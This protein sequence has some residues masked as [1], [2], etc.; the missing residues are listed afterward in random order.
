MSDHKILLWYM[1]MIS[2]GMFF[3]TYWGNWIVTLTHLILTLIILLIF[4]FLEDI[5]NLNKNRR[6]K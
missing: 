4:I 6:Y 5:Y 1:V 2:I 3:G